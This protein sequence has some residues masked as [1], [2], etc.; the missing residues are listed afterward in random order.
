MLTD[1]EFPK[2]NLMERVS[3]DIKVAAIAA[4][5]PKLQ[6][7]GN[8]ALLLLPSES[9]TRKGNGRRVHFTGCIFQIS[10][11]LTSEAR[12]SIK[13]IEL[14]PLQISSCRSN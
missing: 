6:P 5:A 14:A 1:Q 9:L 4:L 8:I 3:T 2:Q 13:S 11:S 10:D 12:I 7:P